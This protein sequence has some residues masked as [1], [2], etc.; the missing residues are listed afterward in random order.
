M[1]Q[2]MPRFAFPSQLG[3]YS[4]ATAAYVRNQFDAVPTRNRQKSPV[5]PIV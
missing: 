4:F 3:S 2:S 1:W 5:S